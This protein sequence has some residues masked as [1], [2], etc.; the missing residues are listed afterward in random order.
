MKKA[1]L[2]SGFIFISVFGFSPIDEFKAIFIYHAAINKDFTVVKSSDGFVIGDNDSPGLLK[3]LTELAKAKKV[4][5]GEIIVTAIGNLGDVVGCCAMFVPNVKIGNFKDTCN[6]SNT[7]LYIKGSSG[8]GSE[9]QLSFFIVGEKPNT[10]ILQANMGGA[11][12]TPSVKVLAMG[13]KV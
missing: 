1:I 8:C 11:G 12:L 7:L 5:G 10:E 2:L 6:S 3:M 9:A 4:K 13:E